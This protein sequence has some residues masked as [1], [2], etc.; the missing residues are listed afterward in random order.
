MIPVQIKVREDVR[1]KLKRVAQANGL[2]LN[3]VATMC[4]ASG[5]PKVEEKL[6]EIHNPPPE[7]AAA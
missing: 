6:H 4:L 3:D 1:M 2:S 7:L 5:L